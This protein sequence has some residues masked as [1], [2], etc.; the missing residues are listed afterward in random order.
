MKFPATFANALHA[1]T[2]ILGSCMP[3]ST[4]VQQLNKNDLRYDQVHW[5]IIPGKQEV[6]GGQPPL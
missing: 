2:C 4:V 1:V 6:K 5:L 3:A